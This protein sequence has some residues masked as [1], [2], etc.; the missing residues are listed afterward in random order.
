MTI[1]MRIF[2]DVW[3]NARMFGVGKFEIDAKRIEGT[4]LGVIDG[5]RAD[6]VDEIDRLRLRKDGTVPCFGKKRACKISVQSPPKRVGGESK[7]RAVFVCAELPRISPPRCLVNAD[8]EVAKTREQLSKMD[9]FRNAV[10]SSSP[11]GSW[12]P[13]IPI[14]P[15]PSR[16]CSICLC[17]NADDVS[18][19][20]SDVDPDSH[21]RCT[22]MACHGCKKMHIEIFLNDPG[23]A[24]LECVACRVECVDLLRKH[25]D[26]TLGRYLIDPSTFA[27]DL[28]LRQTASLGTKES[29]L[30]AFF[31]VSLVRGGSDVRLNYILCP[32]CPAF[33]DGPLTPSC[34]NLV[35][36]TGIRCLIVS[37]V[38]CGSMDRHPP[39]KCPEIVRKGMRSKDFDPNN[40]RDCPYPRC[41]WRGLQHYRD[42]GCH[43]ISCPGCG[44]SFCFACGAPKQGGIHGLES[45][46]GRGCSCLICCW[47]GSNPCPC[48]KEGAMAVVPYPR[49]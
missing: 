39:E 7:V 46:K 20:I 17:E 24:M 32:A 42:Q 45:F 12:Q 25:V 2:L 44:G 15:Q 37:C 31:T 29:Y 8:W 11:R 19:M 49:I 5:A 1:D 48:V 18:P 30:R 43:L 28:S 22:H 38:H 14:E 40:G 4:V 10:A 27:M 21:F 34:Q 23:C 47:G 13:S 3:K 26:S 35:R 6:G 33:V 16:G 41:G 36:C 9:A